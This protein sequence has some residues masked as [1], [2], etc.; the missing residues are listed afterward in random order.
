MEIVLVWG[1]VS[2]LY[3]SQYG[4]VLW[5]CAG[6]SVDNRGMILL[7]LDSAYTESK[8]LNTAAVRKR[9]AQE[10]RKDSQDS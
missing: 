6:N 8:L 3:S 1:G 5:I 10:A 2:F 4:A 7:S 9:A